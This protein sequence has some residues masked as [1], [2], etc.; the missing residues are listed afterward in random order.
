MVEAA[1]FCTALGGLKSTAKSAI[2][3]IAICKIVSVALA[4]VRNAENIQATIKLSTD[5]A[6]NIRK[7]KLSFTKSDIINNSGRITISNS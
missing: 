4:F 2:T 5:K 6:A 7:S 1:V 3:I